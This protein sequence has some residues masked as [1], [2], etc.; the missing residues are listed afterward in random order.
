[1]LSS[2]LTHTGQKMAINIKR[3]PDICMPQALTDCLHVYPCRQHDRGIA[4]PQVVQ[5]QL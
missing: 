2:R 3:N 1:M 5:P 4:V